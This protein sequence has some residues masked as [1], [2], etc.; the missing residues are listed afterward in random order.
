MPSVDL[1]DA[2]AARLLRCEGSLTQALRDHSDNRFGLHLV[3]QSTLPLIDLQTGPIS[4]D[5]GIVREV[6]LRGAGEDWV[7]AQ[8]VIPMST[9]EAA[10]WVAE[11]GGQPLGHALFARDDVIRSPLSFAH[12]QPGQPLHQRSAE[13]RLIPAA[14]P[15]FARRSCFFASEAPLLVTEVFLPALCPTP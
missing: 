4:A 15:V 6:I 3:R 10:P 12:V 11:M 14:S 13:L 2:E 8:T 1:P 5:R 9:V 7:F